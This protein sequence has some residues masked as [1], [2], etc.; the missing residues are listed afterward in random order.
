VKK[1]EDGND[2]PVDIFQKYVTGR[3]IGGTDMLG[4][5]PFIGSG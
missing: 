3:K 1:D 2:V 5:H 4:F